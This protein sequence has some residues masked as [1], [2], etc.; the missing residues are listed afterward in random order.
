MPFG[1]GSLSRVID[2]SL[3]WGLLLEIAP[4]SLKDLAGFLQ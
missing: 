1:S 2:S 3:V 4:V